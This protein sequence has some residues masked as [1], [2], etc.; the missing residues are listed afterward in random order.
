MHSR[1]ART[2]TLSTSTIQDLLKNPHADQRHERQPGDQQRHEPRHVIGLRPRRDRNALVVKPLHQRRV[3]RRISLEAAASVKVPWRQPMR[4]PRRLKSTAILLRSTRVEMRLVEGKSSEPHEQENICS[5]P[6]A[7]VIR[8]ALAEPLPG[9][10]CVTHI[11]EI[12][13]PL[14]VPQRRQECPLRSEAIAT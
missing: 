11:K 7:S 2:W 13:F 1:T 4:L 3:A 5:W 10:N 9:G 6:L 12:Q 14:L 8:A